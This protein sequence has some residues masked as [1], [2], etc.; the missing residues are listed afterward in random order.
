M[1][2]KGTLLAAIICLSASILVRLILHIG[3]LQDWGGLA[4]NPYGS[5][6]M[7]Q[8]LYL[9]SELLFSSSLLLFFIA[10]YRKAN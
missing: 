7:L 5:N 2:F 8:G 9:L 6:G 3:M 10:L 4:L 1:T